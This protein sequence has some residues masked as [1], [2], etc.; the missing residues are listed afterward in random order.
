MK[1]CITAAMDRDEKNHRPVIGVGAVVFR[2][3][4]VLTIR[5]GKAPLAGHWSI[6]GGRVKFGEPLETAV[7]REV[8]EETGVSIR[9]TGLI[10]VFEALPGEQFDEHYVLVDYAAQWTHG[11]PVAGDDA[12]AAEFTSIDEALRRFSW[13]QTRLALAK[14]LADRKTA[15]KAL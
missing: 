9:I 6:P 1:L 4:E 13:D 11:E 12:D 5:R 2:G 7:R 14:A 10:G 15:L 8:L 3:D